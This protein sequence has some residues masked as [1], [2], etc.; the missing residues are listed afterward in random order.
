MERSWYY[1]VA[2]K[3]EDNGGWPATDSEMSTSRLSLSEVQRGVQLA[4]RGQ[5]MSLTACRTGFG[6][7]FWLALWH[8]RTWCGRQL[9][10]T[11]RGQERLGRVWSEDGQPEGIKSGSQVDTKEMR[12][13]A[14]DQGSGWSDERHADAGGGALAAT[15]ASAGAC[16]RRLRSRSSRRQAFHSIGGFQIPKSLRTSS[17]SLS[18]SFSHS[19][20]ING[21]QLLPHRSAQGRY[22]PSRDRRSVASSR[23]GPPIEDSRATGRPIL[24]NSKT[25]TTT[26]GASETGNG[27][28]MRW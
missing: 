4:V 6:R 12:L 3:T 1:I 14:I 2:T 25:L 11:A 27:P 13:Q 21:L 28:V 10:S 9:W 26:S 20:Q 23:S 7:G 18:H 15:G 16:S 24:A 22:V 17:M 19:T 5:P 8:A